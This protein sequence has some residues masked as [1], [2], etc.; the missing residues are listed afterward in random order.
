MPGRFKNRPAFAAC[1]A[2]GLKPGEAARAI[3]VT[4]KTV[5]RWKDSDPEF[6]A[7]WA[8]ALDE[9][10]EEARVPAVQSGAGW[11]AVGCHVCAAA[12]VSREV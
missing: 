7:L 4:R 12:L 11:P 6:A 1:I 3:G 10:T 2:R 9:R 5:Y 8:D